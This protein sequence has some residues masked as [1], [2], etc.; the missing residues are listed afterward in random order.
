MLRKPEPDA[1]A[2]AYHRDCML[3]STVKQREGER[4]REPNQHNNPKPN[5]SPALN[6]RSALECGRPQLPPW[7]WPQAWA[8]RAR[9]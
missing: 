6:A 1:E 3:R 4:P 9:Q 5:Q 8:V 7:P 2:L